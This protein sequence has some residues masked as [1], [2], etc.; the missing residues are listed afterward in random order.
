[1]PVVLELLA[2]VCGGWRGG[3]ALPGTWPLDAG[4]FVRGQHDQVLGP[5]DYN[6]HK[7]PR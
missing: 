2:Y 1:M 3:L 4:L 6:V 5:V 7:S